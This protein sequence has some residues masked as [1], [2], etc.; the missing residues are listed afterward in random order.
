M[1]RSRMSVLANLAQMADLVF[2]LMT[3]IVQYSQTRFGVL[4]LNI[5]LLS[6]MILWDLEGQRVPIIVFIINTFGQLYSV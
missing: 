1:F 5:L 4:L 2:H 6:L 3:P